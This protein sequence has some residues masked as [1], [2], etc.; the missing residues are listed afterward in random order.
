VDRYVALLRGINVGGRNI[1]PMSALRE[2]FADLG[3]GD[4]ATYIQSGNV[5]F[6]RGGRPRADLTRDIEAALSRRFGYT[7]S[8]VLRSRRE[9]RTVVASAPRGFG[10]DPDR[11]RYDVIFL[12][13]PLTAAK[14]LSQVP[15]R[16]G[17]DT[18]WA[19]RGVL[20]FQRVVARAS[21]SRLSQV[22][23]MPVY[24]SMT[25]RNWRTTTALRDLLDRDG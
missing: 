6:D 9:M 24:Q 5:T 8:V 7:A 17:V 16:E 4:V 23:G 2:C 15:V 20:Y 21:Q 3:L 25:I 12:K 13:Q 18:V 14:A 19:G 22:V 1:I 11:L 10:T